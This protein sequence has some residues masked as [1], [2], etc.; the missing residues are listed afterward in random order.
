M[1]SV[2]CAWIKGWVNNREAG[3]LRRHRVH[4][5]VTV[6][7]SDKMI[8]HKT[9]I[10]QN[11]WLCRHDIWQAPRQQCCDHI[12][13][14]FLQP[15]CWD[16]CQ[17][18]TWSTG[19]NRYFCNVKKV[20]NGNTSESSF[21]PHPRSAST[22]TTLNGPGNRAYCLAAVARTSILAPYRLGQVTA[23]HLKIGYLLMKSTGTLYSFELQ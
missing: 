19:S 5:A 8:Y 1:F 4:Y 13:R 11:L 3:D 10:P 2:I 15:I 20:S 22:R 7:L 6:M 9:S 17:I 18:W 21:N 23:T 16:T 14:L 12:W